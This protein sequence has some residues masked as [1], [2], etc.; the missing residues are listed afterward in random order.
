MAEGSD[1]SSIGPLNATAQKEG[2]NLT[3]LILLVMVVVVVA[4]YITGSIANALL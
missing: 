2:L 1:H 4:L 3:G